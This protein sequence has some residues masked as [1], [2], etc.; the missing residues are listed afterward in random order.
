MVNI[1]Y[2]RRLWIG[3]YCYPVNCL[4]KVRNMEDMASVIKAAI[5]HARA[6]G[7]EEFNFVLN[8]L[9]KGFYK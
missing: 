5:T 9:V 6:N 4:E 7:Q 2:E 3:W 8:R 1:S